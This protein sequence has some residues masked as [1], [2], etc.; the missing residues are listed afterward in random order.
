MEVEELGHAL[1]KAEPG[2]VAEGVVLAVLPVEVGG[3]AFGDERVEELG[4]P[5]SRHDGVASAN[6]DL[7]RRG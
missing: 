3:H 2:L 4:G 1:D 6:M 5:F 7:D